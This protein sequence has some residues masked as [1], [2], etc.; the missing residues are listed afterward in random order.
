MPAKVRALVIALALGALASAIG[1]TLQLLPLSTFPLANRIA[2]LV[3]HVGVMDYS[4]QL[5]FG[6]PAY[7]GEPNPNIG[8]IDV[9]DITYKKMGFPFPRCYYGQLVKKLKA[10]G[11]KTVVF[12]IDFLNPSRFGPQDDKC[13]ADGLRA[14]PSVLGYT[15]N[16]TSTGQIGVEATDPALAPYAAALGHTTLDTPGGYVIGQPIEIDTGSTGE[17]SN[18][19]FYALAA[20]GVSTFYGKPLNLQA[21]PTYQG[22]MLLLPPRMQHHQDL[23]TETETLQPEYPGRGIESFSS[24]YSMSVS[25]LRVFAKGA[26]I[27][28]GGTA[29]ALTD[30]ADTA[31]GR[32]PGLFINARFADQLMRGYFLRVAP[33]WFDILLAIGLPLLAAV[34][35]TLMRTSQA[36]LISLF[37]TVVYAYLNLAIFVKLLIWIDLVHVVGAMILGTM[38]VAIYRVIN[39]GSQRRMVTNMFGMH[40]SPAIVADILKQDDPKGALALKGKR[41]KATIFYSDIRGFTSMSET[42]TPEEIYTQLNEYFEEMCNIIFEYG[43][44]VDKF[45]GDCVMAVFSAPYQTPDDAKNAVISAVKQQ[46][47]ILELS[48]K[49]KAEGKK[50]FTVGMGINTGEL[51]MGN[52]G[53]SSRMNYTVIGD[54]V[55]V[56]ARLYNVAKGGEIIIS[57]STYSECKEIVDVDELEPVAVKGKVQ[58]IKIYNVKSLKAAGTPASPPPAPPELQPA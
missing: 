35:F 38:F 20:A 49:W 4:Q 33:I 22:V 3:A 56:A 48:A 39:E 45:I 37:A 27:Y 58:P 54:N 41:V 9:D 50:E 2:D 13:F 15:V 55:N 11:A 1:E 34:S 25:E 36:I 6:Q 21:V 57:E 19:H 32:R 46:E 5:G 51:V 23:E 29:T 52:L 43:G 28:I 40:V 31:R 47:K 24:T 44:Y 30:Y 8:I 26:I 7:D 12:D 53:A 42:M 18:Q 14:M 17:H 16:T 10:A